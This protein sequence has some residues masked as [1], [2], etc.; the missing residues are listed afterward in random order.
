M[1]RH[2]AT[3]AV[4]L[5]VASTSVVACSDDE[6]TV[7]PE[8]DAGTDV[9]ESG[10]ADDLPS[11]ETIDRDG[12]EPAEVERIHV[13]SS[14]KTGV[15]PS[16]PPLGAESYFD[17]DLAGQLVDADDL[18]VSPIAGQHGAGSHDAIRFAPADDDRFGAG[19]QIWDLEGEDIS[20]EERLDELRDQFLGTTDAGD[21]APD[22]AFLSQR[23]GIR[24]IVFVAES[25]PYLFVLSC[26][27]DHCSNT[28]TMTELAA[29]IAANH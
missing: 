19:L 28:R 26:D 27:D 24:N 21:E 5:I 8:A 3:I 14:Q 11:V 4:V 25:G 23:S 15:I 7:D 17:A 12:A 6:P 2:L 20:P 18:R 13:E 10:E 22:G 1:L 29:E 9:D 16:D